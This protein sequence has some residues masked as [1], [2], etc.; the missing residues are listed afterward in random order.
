MKRWLG[1]LALVVAFSVA[2]VFLS[3]WQFDRR[4]QALDAMNQ[5]AE[6]YDSP[7]VALADLAN[8]D[9]F[10]QKHEWRRVQITGRYLIDDEVLVRNRPLNGQAGF[11]QVV[12]FQLESGEVVA[13]ERGWL[14]VTSNYEAPQN[15]PMP[16]AELQTVVGHLRP[17]EPTLNREAPSG[18][19]ATINIAA[20]VAEVEL[21]APIF[22]KLYVRMQ[23]ESQA[24]TTNPASLSRPQLTEGNHLSYALQWILFALMALGALVWAIRKEREAMNETKATR[25][26]LVLGQADADAEDEILSKV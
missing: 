6:N 1:W 16:S 23:S 2:C 18:Q 12:P 4:Q 9:T 8:I 26:R 7:V 19:I 20:L 13:I 15:R 22:E 21:Q 3:T 17:A 5:V 11:L 10:D 14:A 25:D 24:M